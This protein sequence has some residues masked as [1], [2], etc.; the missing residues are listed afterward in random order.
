VDEKTR[1]NALMEVGRVF[2]PG[3][4]IDQQDLFAGRLPQVE[5]VIDAVNGKGQHIA[6][7]GEKG[8]GKTSFSNTLKEIFSTQIPLV[9][10]VN[11]DESDDFSTM[12]H[13]AFGEIEYVEEKNRIGFR[14][15]RSLKTKTLAEN[16]EKNVV[17]DAVRKCLQLVGHS[18]VIF[19]EFDRVGKPVTNRLMADTIKNL[20]DNGIR[21][22]ILLV[23]VADTVDGL[24]AEHKSIDRSLS[25]IEM[26]RMSRAELEEIVTKA[27]GKLLVPMKIDEDALDLIVLLSQ[28]LPH[29]THLLAMH[30]TKVAIKADRGTVNLE[31]FHNGLEASLSD[32]K[33][34][35][36]NA[37]QQA[38]ASQRQGTL[39]KQ[40]LLACALADVNDLGF[41]ISA[42]VRDPLC[43]ITGKQ[44]DI[45]N[46]SQHLNAFSSADRGRILEKRGTTRRFQFRFENP[47]LQPYIIMRG[48][49]EGMLE[50]KLRTLL[51]NSR[52]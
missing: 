28:G 3:A 12:W 20:S 38:I 17:P 31:D 11:C 49:K 5:R 9:V 45:P 48:L 32:T 10:K 26:P 13:K 46:F 35:I 50:G 29:Y 25:E 16:L 52:R 37:Y 24:F 27:H 7:F 22:T 21:A 15:R 14:P 43:Q 8:V 1:M 34:T 40:V 30:A 23:G 6:I 18:I 51:E 33:Q 47:L 4:P 2:S 41:F 39:Y 44:Y 36:R 19:D 42:N